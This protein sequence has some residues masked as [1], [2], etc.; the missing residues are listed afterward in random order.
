MASSRLLT[1]SKFD[2]ARGSALSQPA[3]HHRRGPHERTNAMATVS[4]KHPYCHC[5]FVR[6]S[7][8]TP[9]GRSQCTTTKNPAFFLSIGPKNSPNSIFPCQT[10]YF[11]FSQPVWTQPQRSH[12]GPTAALAGHHPTHAGRSCR[13]SFKAARCQDLSA[14]VFAAIR[15]D[16][17][18]YEKALGDGWVPTVDRDAARRDAVRHG[19]CTPQPADF[20]TFSLEVPLACRMCLP[21]R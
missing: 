4:P 5:C 11:S 18:A 13:Q 9:C 7:S 3:L 17:Y 12:R 14:A 1:K 19:R 21:S 10:H 15:S 2:A 6:F 8:Y 20:Y 16:R